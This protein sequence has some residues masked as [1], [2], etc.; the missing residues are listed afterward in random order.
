MVG[1]DA[2]KNVGGTQ[3]GDLC[4]RVA[5]FVQY[6]VAVLADQR[7]VAMHRGGRGIE[8]GSRRDHPVGA[9]HRMLGH[10]QLVDDLVQ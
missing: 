6:L 1:V 7:G 4:R 3:R 9:G 10:R 2:A 5:H 8:A